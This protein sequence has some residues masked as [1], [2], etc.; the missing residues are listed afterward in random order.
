MQRLLTVDGSGSGVD[1]DR[2]DGL[3]SSQFVRVGNVDLG[4]VARIDF[5]GGPALISD[6]GRLQIQAGGAGEG[7]EGNG[8]IYFT[9]S[10]GTVT[11]RMDTTAVGKPCQG[12]VNGWA[13]RRRDGCRHG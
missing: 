12:T 7:E 8:S 13:R 4:E 11:G 10:E 6:T 5:V 2:L 3:D 9:N 1:A